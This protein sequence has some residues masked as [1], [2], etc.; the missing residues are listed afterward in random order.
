[1]PFISFW[2]VTIVDPKMYGD[3]ALLAARSGHMAKQ[4]KAKPG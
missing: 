1:M 4:H 2:L 3:D